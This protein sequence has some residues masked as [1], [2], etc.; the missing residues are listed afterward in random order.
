MRYLEPPSRTVPM[1][2]EGEG[3]GLWREGRDSGRGEDQERGH[4]RRKR[5]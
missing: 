1:E 3:G 5:I 2:E 4:R